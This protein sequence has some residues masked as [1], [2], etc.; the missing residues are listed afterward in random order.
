MRQLLKC[1][2]VLLSVMLGAALP[3]T[4]MG[5]T[6][7]IGM[8]AAV[9]G[10]DPHQSYSP[11][12][13]VQMQVYESLTFQNDTLH[14]VPGLAESWTVVNPTTW[15]FLLRPGVKFHDGSPLTSADVI[16]SIRRAQE[17]TGLRTYAPSLRDV[18]SIEA[19]D[20]RRVRITTSR[21]APFLTAYLASVMIVS[22]KAANNAGEEQFNGGSAAIG[23]GPYRWVKFNR[24]ADVQLTRNP[25]YWGKAEPWEKVIYRFIPNDS[26]RVAALLSGDV[27]VIDAVPPGLYNSVRENERMRLVT[28]VSAFNNYLYIDSGRAVS[29]Y[30]TGLDGK[31]LTTNPLQD[32]RVRRAVSLALNRK[33]LSERAMEGGATPSNQIA[34]PG[35]IGYDSNLPELAYDPREARRL[36]EAAGYPQGFNLTIHCTGDRF[37]GD[38]RTCQAMGQMFTAVGIRTTVEA[39]PSSVFFRRAQSGGADKSP[40]F[41]VSA[42]MF[43]T[44]SGVALEGMTSIVRTF[45]AKAGYGAS[46][47]GRYSDAELD[48][49]IAAAETEMD[50]AKREEAM[51]AA[52]GR[53][54][55]QMAIIPVFFVRGAWGMSRDL[56]LTA[57]GDQY[58][59]ATSIRRAE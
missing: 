15:E 14:P 33:G 40:E 30:V 51:K 58:T 38:G 28:D 48:R 37:A 4:V 2:A 23:T 24:G 18:T 34:P 31:P 17:A 45:D 39:L 44:T 9:D 52:V 21:P 32:V 42:S 25:D 55:D 12:R 19:V 26:A 56:T 7:R 49:L 8:K 3:G 22:A 59:M 35:F 46:N 13:N 1:L 6:L 16:F 47:R 11:N 57:R 20:D 43:A 29:P 50:D 41:S 54:M 53:S 36:L 10:S 27:D 5:Q